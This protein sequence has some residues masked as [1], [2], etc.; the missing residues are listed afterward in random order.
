MKKKQRGKRDEKKERDDAEIP[1]RISSEAMRGVIAILFLALATFLVLARLDVGGIAGVIIYEQ[2]SWLLGVGYLLLPFSLILLTFLTFKSLERKFGIVQ[3]AGMT[4][5]LL[6]ALGMI[7]LAFP[8]DGGVL[9]AWVSAPFI[10]A[11]DTPATVVFLLAFII[12]SLVI[13]F[14]VHLGLLL[15]GLRTRLAD[16]R[17]KSTKE[18]MDVPIL[19]PEVETES[20]SSVTQEVPAPEGREESGREHLYSPADIHF[21]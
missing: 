17:A 12:A 9:G 16:L 1:A 11:V 5:F 7:D 10:L 19:A 2:L 8:G 6:S 4:V 18:M 21:E 15:S 13:A 14:D 3:I 20:D